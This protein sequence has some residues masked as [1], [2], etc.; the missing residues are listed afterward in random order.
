[1]CNL[2]PWAAA[3]ATFIA[4]L[5]A[6]LR[7]E[8][9][10]LWRR[11]DLVGVIRPSGAERHKTQMRWI[12]QSGPVP[13][14]RACDCYYLRLLVQNKGTQRADRVQV[15][16]S[17]LLRHQADGSFVED[18]RF[19][20]MNLRWSH[21]QQA[22]GGPEIFAEGISPEMGKHCDLGHVLDPKFQGLIENPPPAAKPGETVL[23]LDLEV[24]PFTQ[25]HLIL[26]GI[27]RLELK[28]AAANA[29]PKTKII[30]FNLTGRWYA[31]E[32]TMF[33]DGIS[34]QNE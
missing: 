2:G 24:A 21:S 25:S 30:S 17:R 22:S 3:V 28:L 12:D 19:L 29:K 11:P 16:A 9:I 23:T 1:M 7:D 5:V 13:V 33:S 34:V 18:A 27:Y 14:V 31:D 6:L 8:I 32:V 20:P 10:R 26:P 15:F 4:A